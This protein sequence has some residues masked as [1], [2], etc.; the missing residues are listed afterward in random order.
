MR[1]RLNIIVL[2]IGFLAGGLGFVAGYKWHL[3]RQQSFLIEGPLWHQENKL[4]KVDLTRWSLDSALPS[5]AKIPEADG[6]VMLYW[7]EQHGGYFAAYNY[8]YGRR[9]VFVII[10]NEIPGI[11]S[12]VI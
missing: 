4:R 11:L 3:P 10:G 12:P 5:T 2:L 8:A 6:A 7:M 1:S 9:K